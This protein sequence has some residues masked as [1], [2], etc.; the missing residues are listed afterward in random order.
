MPFD[1]IWLPLLY[2]KYSNLSLNFFSKA[3]QCPLKKKPKHFFTFISYTRFI[4]LIRVQALCIARRRCTGGIAQS[5]SDCIPCVAKR[6][7]RQTGMRG[8]K[9]G[10]EIQSLATSFRCALLRRCICAGPWFN[11][12]HPENYLAQLESHTRVLNTAPAP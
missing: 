6:G 12:E 7:G 1:L 9:K 4:S 2:C 3:T 10:G 11:E 8:F 5:S